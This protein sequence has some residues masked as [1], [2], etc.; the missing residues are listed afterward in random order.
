MR[1]SNTAKN[2]SDNVTGSLSYINTLVSNAT[3]EGKYMIVVDGQYLNDSMIEDLSENYGY[4]ISHR[5]DFMGTNESY[6]IRWGIL[7]TR[8]PVPTATPT[9]TPQP[10]T[11]TPTPTVNHVAGVDFTIEWWIKT[12]N[13]TS[14]TY[15]PRPYSLGAFPAPNAVSIE[16][17]GQ[18][19][20]WW[21]S[22]SPE[23]DFNGLNL[24][25][26]TWYHMA[27]TR[28]NGA[29]A[30]YVDGVRKAT[31]TYN[32]AIPSA[33][34]ILT[35]GAEPGDSTVNGKMTNFRWNSSVK[36]TG[37]SFTVPTSPLT[38]DS[39]TKLLLLATNSGTLTTDS[40]TSAKTVTNIGASWSSDSP[41]SGGLGGS[42][43]FAGTGKFTVPASSD[44]D[45]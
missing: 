43:D 5:N 3:S 24:Q 35:I 42:I 17:G 33:G 9:P 34:N 28:D 16:G 2:N 22:G 31:A 12:N 26:N 29:L 23:I 21:T 8:G 44:W 18:H 19:I 7:E 30:I 40:S 10:A 25:P 41:F 39:D 27:V 36:Y 38:A 45:L 14:P 6:T 13:W 37:A 11:A 32:N 15:H 20:Y 1:L 4:S